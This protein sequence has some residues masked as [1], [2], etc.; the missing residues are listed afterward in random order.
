MTATQGCVCGLGA[1]WLLQQQWHHARTKATTIRIY[2]STYRVGERERR[3]RDLHTQSK[4]MGCP[5]L[6]RGRESR[7]TCLSDARSGFKK[8]KKKKMDTRHNK[9]NDDD[10]T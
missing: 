4:K 8:K 7:E 1:A 2:T 6:L 3:R 9:R 5:I 10:D